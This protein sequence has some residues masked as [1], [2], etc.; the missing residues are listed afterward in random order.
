MSAKYLNTLM[1]LV[2][3]VLLSIA[4]DMAHAQASPESVRDTRK[5]PNIVMAFADDWGRYARAY[6]AFE[7]SKS[8]NHL[9]DTPNFDRIAK[10]GVIFKNA[11]VPVPS[12]TPCRS[13][14]L[15]G[16]YFWQTGMG[17]ILPG[18]WD[19]SIPT[20][21]LELEKAGYHIG[22]TYKVWSPG[23]PYD[24]PYGAERTRYQS[25]GRS[26]NSFSQVATRLAPEMG[27]AKAK[28]SLLDETRQN[29]KS[30]LNA[31]PDGEPFCYWWGPTNTHRTW[32]QGSGNSL[33]SLNPDDLKGR[34]PAF[35]PDVHE[36]RE[37]ICDY[38]GEVLAVDAGLGVLLDEL[39]KI[40]ELDNTLVVVSGDH[41]IPGIPRGKCNLYDIG[42]E[43]ALLARWPKK[44]APGRVVDD[45]VNLMDLAPTFLEAAGVPKPEAMTARSLMPVLES[46]ASGQIDPTRTFV[47]TG[48]ETHF[49]SAR[50]G[51][52]PY[53]Q[54][55]I[56]TKDFLYIHNFEPDRWPMGNP[57]GLDDPDTPTPPYEELR[58]T[59]FTAYPDL[60]A[61]PTKAWMVTN[62]NDESVREAYELGFGK[63]P[64]EE[65]FDL[66]VDPDQV[67]NIAD[68]SEYQDTRARLA[69]QLLEILRE[70]EDPRIVEEPIRFENPPYTVHISERVGQ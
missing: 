8:L 6:A 32:T 63:R 45:F 24:A 40:G 65:L 67:R 43:V 23:R 4:A 28:E 64:Q 66:R 53:P 31:R 44:I 14:I 68:I 12:C 46:K 10:E 7:G 51:N 21:P 34:L 35:L 70:Q 37:D 5:R 60:D 1:V 33:W 38:L 18:R 3:L 36:V 20:Y 42:T 29:F 11:F 13:S 49:P 25:A 15:S 69:E 50:D 47:V 55:A 2:G 17:A 62:R 30:F 48:R 27:V 9:I 61:S 26:F 52:L 56:R 16:R 39:E 19:D 22:H 54:R 41:G 59:T 58:D 57:R